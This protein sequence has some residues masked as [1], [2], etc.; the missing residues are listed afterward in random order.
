MEMS[1]QLHSPA[2]LPSGKELPVHFLGDWVSPRIGISTVKEE[3]SPTS[4]ENWSPAVQPVGHRY[5]DGAIPASG[6]NIE[7]E[8]NERKRG[9][10]KKFPLIT[11]TFFVEK[12]PHSIADTCSL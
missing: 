5:T 6:M 4:A 3:Q 11:R 2:A 8:K 10:E 7:K 12:S 1:G 9:R